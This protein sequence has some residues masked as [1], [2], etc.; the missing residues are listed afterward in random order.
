MNLISIAMEGDFA[1]IRQTDDYTGWNYALE[2][3]ARGHGTPGANVQKEELSFSGPKGVYEVVRKD[4]ASGQRVLMSPQRGQVAEVHDVDRSALE[5]EIPGWEGNLIRNLFVSFRFYNLIPALMKPN[6]TAAANV[7]DEGGGNF[8]AWMLMLHTRYQQDFQ[9]INLAARG[10]LPDLSTIYTFPTQQATVFVASE[11]RFLRTPV[12]AWQ[13][14]DGALCFIAWLSLIFCPEDLTGP[15]YC[16]E[17][18]E[19]HLHPRLIEVLLDLLYQKQ[20]DPNIT[21]AQVFATTHSLTVVDRT[22]LD[23][24][25]VFERKDGSTV[26]TRPKE[27]SHL[28]QLIGRREVGLGDLYYAGALGRD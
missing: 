14:A 9:K 28:R 21:P 12:P 6:T 19:N 15:V 20:G 2:F 11:E 25:V 7:L 13:M 8:A 17:E 5:F 4:R 22:A 26:C 27:K 3:V 16:V 1:G 23:D 24:I 18:L 10:A